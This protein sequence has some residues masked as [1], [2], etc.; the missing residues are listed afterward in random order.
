[1][2]NF[3]LIAALL[4]A[5]LCLGSPL[6]PE[7][8]LQRVDK[9][10]RSV[11]GV[12]L[13][14]TLKAAEEPTVYVFG[15]PDREGFLVVSADDA[16]VALL[17]YSEDNGFDVDNISP[18]LK[19]WL[20]EYSRQIQY[21]RQTSEISPST[22]AG[23]VLPG[24][25]P[26][27]PFLKTRWNQDAPYNNL[28]P[29]INQALPPTGC[30][31]TSMA[32]V[33][34]Y[35]NYPAAGKGSISY[36][37]S[38]NGKTYNLSQN[39]STMIFDWSNMLNS[40]S[41]S[42]TDEQAKAVATLMRA[43]GFSVEMQYDTDGSGAYST[44]ISNALVDY[45]GYDPGIRYYYRT[46]YNY[47][48][49]AKMLY[50][51]LKE[52]YP[53]IYNGTGVGGSHSFVFDG[54]QDSGYFH[55]NWGWGGVSNGYFLIDALDPYS[56]GTGGGAGGF[57]FMQG[58]V[59]NIKPATQ[60]VAGTAQKDIY[61]YG[62]LTGTVDNNTLSVYMT[63]TDYPVVLFQ[64]AG[65][66]KMQLGVK[67]ENM[68][69]QT[70]NPVYLSATN[71]FASL[72]YENM[73]GYYLRDSLPM[74]IDLNGQTL[75]NNVQYKVTLVYRPVASTEWS[76]L[77]VD[78]GFSNYFYL[79]RTGGSVPAYTIETQEVMLF[80]ASDVELESEFYADLPVILSGTLINDND[81]ELTRSASIVLFDE[82][83]EIAFI[84]DNYVYSLAPGQSVTETWTSELSVYD[85]SDK[86]A[87]FIGKDLYIGLF[88]YETGYVY[89]I[90]ETPVVMNPYPG[91]PT[92]T[93]VIYV[94]G[95]EKDAAGS[96]IVEDAISF[97]VTTEI[98]V[99]KGYFF[100]TALLYIFWPSLTN[101]GYYES[102][103][104]FEYDLTPIKEG[105]T[106]KLT[107]D[108]SYPDAV[109]GE[110]YYLDTYVF[111]GSEP[112]L[113]DEKLKVSFTVKNNSAGIDDISVSSADILFFHNRITGTLTV[114]GEHGLTNVD[115]YSIDGKKLN[116]AV[117]GGSGYVDIDLNPL[118]SGIIVV[119][120]SDR[121][122]NQKSMKIA[123]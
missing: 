86:S 23:I 37:Y 17:G 11:Q 90:N 66:Q 99:Q 75:N 59:V 83:G 50:D 122:G 62:S 49:W 42:Y 5:S 108:A 40:Y 32:Q 106:K 58:A 29:K 56:I 89:Y 54:Y 98:T 39:F 115:V 63:D 30:V 91:D 69:S 24:W 100:N 67:I 77:L 76:D 12:K 33:M 65:T 13:I 119:N 84:G 52:G 96:Y 16:A 41:G 116:S 44:M 123:L 20:E 70:A 4:S 82:E 36:S 85:S 114:T 78:E 47:S 88:D 71:D 21:L 120:A 107:V 10:T 61:A 73:S 110:R 46:W 55:I 43:A 92:Y 8:A 3:L 45:F 111:V 34:K 109:V 118:G 97:P 81:R 28:C 7:Q 9:G 60:G 74:T 26:I 6:T 57:N 112:T 95:A 19:Y 80:S 102:N 68:S 22:R 1:M 51:N 27:E 64:G 72:S 104:Y 15:N 101:P 14:E 53:V 93:G 113:I 87:D 31:A 105:E 35:Y 94:E 38:I 79:T 2:R 25:E 117:A 18:E 103:L 48:S 121:N